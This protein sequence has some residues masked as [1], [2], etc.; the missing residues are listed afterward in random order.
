MIAYFKA[1]EL[2]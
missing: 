2:L 1:Y